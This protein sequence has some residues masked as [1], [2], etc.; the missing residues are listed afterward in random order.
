VIDRGVLRY[1][2]AGHVP[3]LVAG[4]GDGDGDCELCELPT[5][6]LPLGV[7]EDVVYAV[8][9]LPFGPEALLFAST[10]G[11]VEARRA[12]ELF[13]QERVSALVAANAP[14]LGMQALVELAYAEAQAFADELTDDIA[15]IA[16]RRTV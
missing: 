1:A 12:G 2:N 10:D 6:G 15:I 3:P 11:L 7:E 16:L 4:P 5:T 8:R 13:G 9:E 14:V